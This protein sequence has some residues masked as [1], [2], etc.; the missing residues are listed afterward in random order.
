MTTKR[1]RWPWE[2]RPALKVH[3]R[4]GQIDLPRMWEDADIERRKRMTDDELWLDIMQE[5]REAA[6]LRTTLY[7]A[8]LAKERPRVPVLI[9]L[10]SE[11]FEDYEMAAMA[12]PPGPT[13]DCFKQ[14]MALSDLAIDELSA[15]FLRM[16]P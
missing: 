7:A 9:K 2:E 1:K 4:N 5:F 12:T 8:E 15:P 13:Q 16:L 14:E 10:W 11:N 3:R 6:R